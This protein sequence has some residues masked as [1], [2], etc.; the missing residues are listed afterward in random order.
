MSVEVHAA[1]FGH[2]PTR[3]V[4]YLKNSF[5]SKLLPTALFAARFATRLGF[6]LATFETSFAD[7]AALYN[8]LTML[9]ILSHFPM[10]NYF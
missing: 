3:V 8:S 1:L 2:A 6:P 7:R 5:E 9:L 10:L 4:R